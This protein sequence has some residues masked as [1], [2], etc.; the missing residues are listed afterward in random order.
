MGLK[1]R[2][3]AW[4]SELSGGEA[5][6]AALARSLVREP[7]LLLADEPFGALD[8][9]TR[10]KMHALLRELWRRHQPSVLLVTHDVDEAI[11]LADRV[12]VLEEGRIRVDLVVDHERPR[13][14]YRQ[15]LLGA[16]GVTSGV[17]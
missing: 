12:L 7:E 5:Q 3:R 2:E 9:L 13:D 15:V 10:I 8:A 11:V 1:G 6:R 16:L 4:P 14:E 17:R